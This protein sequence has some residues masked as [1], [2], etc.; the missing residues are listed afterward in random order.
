MRLYYASQ[1][2]GLEGDDCP[3]ETQKQR[4]D[5]AKQE[6]AVLREHFP[7][8]E[9]IVPHENW[10]VNDLYAAGFVT[11]DQM[12]TVEKSF[13][14]SDDCE[15]VVSVGE[16]H[17]NTG[18]HQEL[19]TAITVGKFACCLDDPRLSPQEPY[20]WVP[21]NELSRYEFPQGNRRLLIQLLAAHESSS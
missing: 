13:I 12:L 11:G 2:R 3:W 6:A 15:G 1:I 10:I 7:E 20:R 16:V 4:I 8:I 5:T 17:V 18:V 14:M 9:F 21:R 19:T